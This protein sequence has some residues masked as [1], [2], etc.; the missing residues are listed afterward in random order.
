VEGAGQGFVAVLAFPFTEDPRTAGGSA[1]L[2]F[3]SVVM[4]HVHLAFL[5]VSAC[6]SARVW[7]HDAAL[8]VAKGL[9][10]NCNALSG[11]I[12]GEL[13][14]AAAAAGEHAL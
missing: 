3:G 4:R 12:D 11:S 1:L 10:A 8:R 7:N 6:V 2:S 9:G 5:H 13:G 14:V